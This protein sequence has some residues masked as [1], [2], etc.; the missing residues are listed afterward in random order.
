MEAGL[1]LR[2]VAELTGEDGSASVLL[3]GW[4]GEEEGDA[5]DDRCGLGKVA[6]LV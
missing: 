6:A 2:A 4:E 5:A 3:L 1:A